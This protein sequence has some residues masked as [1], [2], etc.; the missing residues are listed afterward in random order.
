MH[1]GGT[2]AQVKRGVGE[3]PAPAAVPHQ[4][5]RLGSVSAIAERKSFPARLRLA[6]AVVILSTG[7]G[8]AIQIV[9]IKFISLFA[10]PVGSHRRVIWTL[11]LTVH[12]AQHRIRHGDLHRDGT[13]VR[14]VV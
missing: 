2:K 3:A 14:F 6:M 7:D 13:V 5:A 10:V 9:P 12:H 11:F 1:L 4:L 8:G